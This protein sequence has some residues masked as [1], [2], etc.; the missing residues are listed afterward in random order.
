MARIISVLTAIAW[1]PVLG[2][3]VS[4]LVGEGVRFSDIATVSV[5]IL[6]VCAG[7]ALSIWSAIR[8]RRLV[9]WML[10]VLSLAPACFVGPV[11]W[12]QVRGY[13]IATLVRLSWTVGFW[14][15]ECFVLVLL[16]FLWIGVC[17]QLRGRA[18]HAV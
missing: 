10:L 2:A 8:P 11:A 5:A 4:A 6:V 1:I 14:L 3:C 17:W 7:L 13:G 16:P 15:F 18:S 9:A 12:Q